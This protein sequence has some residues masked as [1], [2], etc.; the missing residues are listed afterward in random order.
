[1]SLFPTIVLS[2]LCVIAFL[3][4]ES[5]IKLLISSSK[6]GNHFARGSSLVMMAS[7]KPN[8]APVKPTPF[9]PRF[10][11]GEMP[12]SQ[13]FHI[14]AHRLCRIL[15]SRVTWIRGQ[16]DSEDVSLVNSL[17]CQTKCIH[18]LYHIPMQR[19]VMRHGQTGVFRQVKSVLWCHMAEAGSQGRQSR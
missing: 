17:T 8:K 13:F 14:S 10:L 5:V 6:P 1:M 11:E 19:D 15:E 16:L 3:P 4:G 12:F 18:A 7:I 9:N 2:L